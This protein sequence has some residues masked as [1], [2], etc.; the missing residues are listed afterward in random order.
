MVLF[1]VIHVSKLL[2]IKMEAKELD[3]EY[4]DLTEKQKVCFILC[5]RNLGEECLED[6]GVS[7]HKHDDKTFQIIFAEED[8]VEDE[9]AWEL[10]EEE[11]AEEEEEGLFE[12]TIDKDC[13][14]NKPIHK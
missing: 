14:N 10:L 2:V 12:I 11:E 4:E 1:I 3:K 6:L 7:C 8:L 5:G 9:D 13:D